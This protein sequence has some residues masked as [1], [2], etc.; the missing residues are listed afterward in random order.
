MKMN[1]VL[2]STAEI[3]LGLLVL[4][5]PM[6]YVAFSRRTHGSEKVT[7]VLLLCITSWIGL[8]FYLIIAPINKKF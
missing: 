3:I 7:W 8:I 4:L 1:I 6:L 5:A 2:S